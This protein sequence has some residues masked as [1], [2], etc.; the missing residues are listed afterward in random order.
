M[1]GFLVENFMIVIAHRGNMSG[2]NPTSE[3][4]PTYVAAALSAGFNV[5]IDIWYIDNHFVLGHNKPEH[6]ISYMFLYNTKLW[7]HCKNVEALYNLK[8]NPAINS[9]FHDKDDCTLTSQGFI[10][11]Y[12]RKDILITKK[13]VAVMPESVD[14]WDISK[15]YAVCTDYADKYIK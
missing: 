12:P 13:S 8:D 4:N 3:N 11:S 6:E 2:P 15:A 7:A 5:E 1:V 14:G 9:F 10:W